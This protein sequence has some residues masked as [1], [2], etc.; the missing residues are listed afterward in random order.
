MKPEPVGVCSA[1]SFTLFQAYVGG[2]GRIR[3]LGRL[4]H[5]ID[6]MPSQAAVVGS[7]PER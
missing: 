6:P 5:Q 7:Q 1:S 3:E 2:L 4:C